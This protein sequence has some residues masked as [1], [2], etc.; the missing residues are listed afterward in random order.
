[1]KLNLTCDDNNSEPSLDV[2]VRISPDGSCIQIYYDGIK[3]AWLSGKDGSV[4][5]RSVSNEEKAR[6]L[7][8]KVAFDQFARIWRAL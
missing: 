6:L 8:K 7:K 5:C 1:M 4:Q 3:V 2:S